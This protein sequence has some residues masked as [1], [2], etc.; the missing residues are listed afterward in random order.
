MLPNNFYA[1]MY[2]PS[3]MRTDK[4]IEFSVVG[5]GGLS[6]I[7]QGNF[8]ISDLITTS[9]GSPVLDIDNF[10]ESINKNNYKTG[11]FN[12]NDFFKHSC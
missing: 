2:N 9:S 12:P 7:N 3:Y 10:Y 4:A 11:Y 1:Q 5:F 6:F 8:K